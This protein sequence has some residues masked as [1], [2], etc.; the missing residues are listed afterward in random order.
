MG[1]L[2]SEQS[3]QSHFYFDE[4]S[5]NHSFTLVVFEASYKGSVSHQSQ[6]L[7]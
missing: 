2:F 4:Q 1:D 6:G 5:L 3:T 7:I